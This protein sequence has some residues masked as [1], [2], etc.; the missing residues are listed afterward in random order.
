MEHEGLISPADGAKPR[1]V[2]QAAYHLREQK[3]QNVPQQADAATEDV[4]TVSA[5]DL[6]PP[7][8]IK[9]YTDF[10]SIDSLFDKSGF[11]IEASQD[12]E[13]I[14][15]EQWD[16][17]IYKHTKFTSWQ[18]MKK[19]AFDEYCYQRGIKGRLKN[20]KSA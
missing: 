11:K 9:N 3:R 18:Q 14:P 10:D 7:E 17:F 8:F 19:F 16:A 20:D 5:N 1:K 12:I 6:F 15:E 13:N 2:L 4:R